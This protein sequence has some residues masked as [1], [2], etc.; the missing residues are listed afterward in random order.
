[1]KISENCC[2]N[3]AINKKTFG[4]ENYFE[5]SELLFRKDGV[6]RL[7]YNRYNGSVELLY[8]SLNWLVSDKS[9]DEKFLNNS[10]A[11]NPEAF[12]DYPT[13]TKQLNKWVEL[14]ERLGIEP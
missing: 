7:E 4:H 14:C 9:F 12:F 10:G 1:M 5:D 13:N 2:R 3:P 11:K 6:D 8:N